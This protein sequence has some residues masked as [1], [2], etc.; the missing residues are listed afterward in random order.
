MQLPN[1]GPELVAIVR[2]RTGWHDVIILN[3][4]IVPAT[5]P[6]MLYLEEGGE[7]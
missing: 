2:G 1:S 7:S 4:N 6:D 3:R 5:D